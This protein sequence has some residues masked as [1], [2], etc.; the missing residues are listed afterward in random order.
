MRE[1]WAAEHGLEDVATDAFDRH[2]DAVWERIKVNDE[3]SELQQA[4]R[5]R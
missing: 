3:C 4:A 1:Q 2:L 5:R